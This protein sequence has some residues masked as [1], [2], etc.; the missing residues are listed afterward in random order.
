MEEKRRRG[1]PRLDDPKNNGIHFRVT[2]KEKEKLQKLTDMTGKTQSEI[3][4]AGIDALY[5]E[6]RRKEKEREN[7]YKRVKKLSRLIADHY[8]RTDSPPTALLRE[9]S[10]LLK[11]LEKED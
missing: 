10:D 9:Y 5:R 1:R 6:E 3:L 2:D 7:R 4:V 8:E 11:K